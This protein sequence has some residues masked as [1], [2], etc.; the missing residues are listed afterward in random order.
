[1]IE[2]SQ[3]KV[4][5]AHRGKRLDVNMYESPDKNAKKLPQTLHTAL[6]LLDQSS[7]FREM[8]GGECVD[9]YLKLKT[10]E[11]N[12]Y[13]GHVSAWERGTYLDS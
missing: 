5:I 13:L 11:W 1:M 2:T 6:G 4:D 9:S 12:R 10:G 3:R 8:L 7:M